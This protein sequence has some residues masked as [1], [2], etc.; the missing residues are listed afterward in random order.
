MLNENRDNVSD[1]NARTNVTSDFVGANQTTPSLS[2][3]SLG[4]PAVSVVTG[5][6]A[7]VAI[8]AA[9]GNSTVNMGAVMTVEVSGATTIAGGTYNLAHISNPAGSGEEGSAIFVISALNAGLNTFTAVYRADLGG[10]AFF[11]RRRIL[12]HP[13]NK[14]S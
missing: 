6:N 8:Q 4:G 7:L 5:S 1:L 11:V 9:L 10:T 13:A 12:V 3:V 2:T 14:L